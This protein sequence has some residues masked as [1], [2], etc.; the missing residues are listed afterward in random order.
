MALVTDGADAI[1]VPPFV[2]GQ[3]PVGRFAFVGD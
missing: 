2:P 1:I 3:P